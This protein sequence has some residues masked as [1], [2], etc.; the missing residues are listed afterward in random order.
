[1]VQGLVERIDEDPVQDPLLAWHHAVRSRRVVSMVWEP[2]SR[3]KDGRHAP[4][5]ARVMWS[6]GSDLTF[7]AARRREP[8]NGI[9]DAV[10]VGLIT[11]HVRNWREGWQPVE[12]AERV[13]VRIGG[14]ALKLPGSAA[15]GVVPGKQLLV[16][17]WEEP[18]WWRLDDAGDWLEGLSVD[19]NTQRLDPLAYPTLIDALVE[20]LSL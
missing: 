16:A 11:P 12:T 6:K 1:M 20:A 17:F 4:G 13:P 7:I 14:H 2:A 19:P 15:V 9:S 3:L 8:I 18:V 10:V 5:A